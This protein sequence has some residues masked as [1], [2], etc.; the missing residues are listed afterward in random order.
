MPIMDCLKLP[1]QDAVNA[2][3]ENLSPWLQVAA[4]SRSHLGPRSE[5]RSAPESE[6]TPGGPFLRR[7]VLRR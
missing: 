2:C 5:P 1:D 6:R 4:A 3:F 7:V